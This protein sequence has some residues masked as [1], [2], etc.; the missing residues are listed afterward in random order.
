MVFQG[1]ETCVNGVS[2]QF[3]LSFG[4]MVKRLGAEKARDLNDN[5][6]AAYLSAKRAEM[7]GDMMDAGVIPPWF[8]QPA[9]CKVCGDVWIGTGY[10]PD[11]DCVPELESCPWCPAYDTPRMTHAEFVEASRNRREE[12]SR[13]I[14]AGFDGEPSIVF[15]AD[16]PWPRH[17][18]R[19]RFG[20][21][22]P[23]N[24]QE[25]S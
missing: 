9:K 16:G 2:I 4:D 11:P 23:S 13:S 18:Y 5:Y 12:Y 3:W 25:E 8:T 10:P 17:R 15:V 7:E 6:P 24:A 20:G 22:T 19:K 21:R 14:A 1:A